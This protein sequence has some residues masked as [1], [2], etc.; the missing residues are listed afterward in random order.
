VAKDIRNND[1]SHGDVI[2]RLVEESRREEE[3]C[4]YTS[5][6]FFIWLRW[7]KGFR[8]ALWVGAAVGSGLAASHILRG[9]PAFRVTMAF[10]ALAGVLLPAVGRALHLDGS[11]QDYTVAARRFK[12]LQGEFRR[13]AQVWSLKPFTQFEE[14][15]RRLFKAMAEA[16][17]P[18][19]TPPEI[20]FRLARRKIHKGHYSYDAD[21]KPVEKAVVTDASPPH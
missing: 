15:A 2:A 10:A 6:A 3:N 12:N 17:K 8:A 1:T 18:S 13:A 4:L 21:E 14:E 7:L 16:R 11:I 19:L 20:V 9:D 5:T